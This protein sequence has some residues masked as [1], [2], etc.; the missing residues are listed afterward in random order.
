MLGN[1]GAREESHTFIKRGDVSS[2]RSLTSREDDTMKRQTRHSFG[3]T[4]L[5]TVTLVTT[6]LIQLG[7]DGQAT[8][9]KEYDKD[10]LEQQFA[11]S[12]TT[13]FTTSSHMM[14]ILPLT[15]KE[16]HLNKR[17][18]KIN[19]GAASLKNKKQLGLTLFFLGLAGEKI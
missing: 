19:A 3:K 7:V 15:T 12:L 16:H 9:L 17:S 6:L 2:E 4:C 5:A 14:E 13:S 8:V 10:S 18:A 11:S 1:Y